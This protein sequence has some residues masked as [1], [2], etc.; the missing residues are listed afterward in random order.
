MRSADQRLRDAVL[1][2]DSQ[3]VDRL[4]VQSSELT[5][6]L[7][8]GL[9][10]WN[11]PPLAAAK[12]VEVADVLMRHG[13]ELGVVSDWWRPGFG[14][15]QVEPATA[16]YLAAKGAQL[17]A[18]AAAGM[19][20]IDE[21]SAMLADDAT[22]ATAK[23]GD[24]CHP[25]HFCTRRESVELLLEHGADVDA[26]DDDHQSTPAQW[27]IGDSPETV[28]LLLQRGATPDI[29][30]A[31]ALGDLQLARK[32]VGA[33]P[34]CTS[35]RIG[36]NRGPFPGIGFQ[37]RGGTIYQW[38]LGFN[39]SP[40]EVALKRGHRDV[41]E[42]LLDKT[43]PRAKFLVGCTSANRALAE[44]VAADH[45][46]IVRTLDEEDH[47]LLAKFCWETNKNIET[48]RLML[49]LGFPVDQPEPN[50]G[51]MALHNAAWCG[52]PDLVRLLLDRGHPPDS[53]DPDYG[54][55][56]IGWAVHSC[57]EAKRHPEGKFAE[58]VELLLLSGTPF[59][60]QHYPVGHKGIDAVI[61]KHLRLEG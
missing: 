37:G 55:T 44:S 49:D 23:G 15:G 33:D 4:L 20:L 54:S 16:R 48:V 60:A 24:G 41:Y 26:R 3:D 6:R 43:E 30:M 2:D 40:H 8:E 10:D 1:A 32:I 7:N 50:H 13:A 28:Q 17:S 12:S 53:R 56:P 42:F 47:A 34:D 39:L 21:L 61:R 58:V 22:L 9:F 46:Q 27:R 38:S 35:Y 52:D 45:P 5:A 51:F 57:L 31:T 36:N 11:M 25:L 19:G 18:H 29:F 14:V 59:D